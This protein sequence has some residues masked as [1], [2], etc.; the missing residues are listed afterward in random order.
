MLPRQRRV[1]GHETMTLPEL[2][3]ADWRRDEGH[4]ASVRARSSARSGWRPRR[5]ATTGGTSRCT[6]TSAGLTTRRLH[7]RGTTFEI[8]HR[9]RRSR[10]GRADRRRP[11]EVVRARRRS[12]GRGLR[13]AHPRDARRARHRRRDQGGAVRC[14][15]DDAVCSGRRRMRPGIASAIARFGRI[16]DWS[17]S[18]FEEFSGWFN[19]KTSP[20]HLFWH[21]LDLAV[22]RF[23]GRPAPPVDADR[24]HPGG[25]LARGHLVRVLARRRQ[26]RR[27]R[28]LLLH[29]PRARRAARPAAVGG[30]VDRVG[31]RLAGDPPL[32]DRAHAHATPERRCSRSARA[33]T[34]PA[35]ASPAGT[36]PASS[37]PGARPRPAPT[38]HANAA[39]EFGRTS[40]RV[41]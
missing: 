16:L 33:P 36:P 2:H 13:C 3:L 41:R 22:T 30:C 5:R 40:D 6:S 4:A 12:A 34:R 28:L 20:V 26:R 38:A 8:T 25:L 27:R 24:G 1:R 21:S 10:A 7:H 32:R 15:D 29:R 19:G 31:L 18:V 23:S 39:A 9:L 35:P 11:D 17:D 37:R 14:P